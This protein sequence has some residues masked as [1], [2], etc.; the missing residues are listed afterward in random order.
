MRQHIETAKNTGRKLRNPKFGRQAVRNLLDRVTNLVRL[1]PPRALLR[2]SMIVRQKLT[3]NALKFENTPAATTNLSAPPASAPL[4]PAL[5]LP[6][7]PLLLPHLNPG[8][9]AI[10]YERDWSRFVLGNT[11]E[12][13]LAEKRKAQ[14]IDFELLAHYVQSVRFRVSFNDPVW[15]LS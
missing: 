3:G 12:V 7:P 11:S 15:L 14:E 1:H 4:L 9:A 6:L 10:C 5:P 8:H 2:C 13:V